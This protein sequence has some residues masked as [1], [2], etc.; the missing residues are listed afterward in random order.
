M[1]FWDLRRVVIDNLRRV[2]DKPVCLEIGAIGLG[3]KGWIA[4]EFC[5][6]I[7]N[8]YTI[9]KFSNNLFETL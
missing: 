2:V 1:S 4:D 7:H 8:N 9:L 5:G 3:A 6:N